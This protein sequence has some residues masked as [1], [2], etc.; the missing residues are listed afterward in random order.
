MCMYHMGTKA[1]R[2]QKK[3]LDPLEPELEMVVNHRWMLGTEPRSSARVASA[4]N[5]QAISPALK[6]SFYLIC[7]TVLPACVDIYTTWGPGSH[8]GGKRETDQLQLELLE[9][10]SQVG[11]G[12]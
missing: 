12:S 2:G 7:M 5:H 10:V 11:A 9:V 3:A 8:G 6:I 4:F 1:L